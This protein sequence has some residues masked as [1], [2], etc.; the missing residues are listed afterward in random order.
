MKHTANINVDKE[1]KEVVENIQKYFVKKY[2]FEPRD[3]S[4]S[5][6]TGIIAKID[7]DTNLITDYIFNDGKVKHKT[8]RL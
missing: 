5:K 3:I 1:F 2:G 7:K 6:V 4:T 8:M